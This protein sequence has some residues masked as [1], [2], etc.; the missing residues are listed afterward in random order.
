MQPLHG[1]GL[2]VHKDATVNVEGLVTITGSKQRRL[3]GSDDH[4]VN[5]NVY[6]PTFSKYLNINDELNVETRIGVTS[7]IR[8]TEADYHNN[9][10][11]PVAV[12]GT[13]EIATAAWEHCN[14][15]DDQEWFFVNGN[16]TTDPASPRTTY[17]N[18]TGTK[19]RDNKTLYFGWTWASVVRTAPTG[20]S[21]TAIDT[22]EELAWLITKDS[23]RMSHSSKLRTSIWVSMCGCR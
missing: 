14:F 20:Y 2:Y 9:T 19:D 6:L 18:S 23:S 22:P 3:V 17:Y 7:P 1:G 16:K 8:N 12:A 10:L 21:A 15:L 4:P 13:K 5:S 11:S